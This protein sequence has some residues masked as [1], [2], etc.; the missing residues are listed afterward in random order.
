[1]P[2]LESSQIRAEMVILLAVVTPRRDTLLIHDLELSFCCRTSSV[3]L[4]AD[5]LL[6]APSPLAGKFEGKT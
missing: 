4:I 5:K 1:M 3:I 6:T 2:L